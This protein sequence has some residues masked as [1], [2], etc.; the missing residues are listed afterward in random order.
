MEKKMYEY[1]GMKG[2]R[3]TGR[4]F[5]LEQNGYRFSYEQ[6]HY[7]EAEDEEKLVQ[8]VIQIYL[9]EEKQKALSQK[10]HDQEVQDA[11]ALLRIAM[12]ADRTT[13]VWRGDDGALRIG[14]YGCWNLYLPNYLFPS[15]APGDETTLGQ[16]IGNEV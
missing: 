10:G 14:V 12:F 6:P 8:A 3:L 5:L 11:L 7:V 13:K 15:V 2:C 1:K 9:D 4:M 16:I